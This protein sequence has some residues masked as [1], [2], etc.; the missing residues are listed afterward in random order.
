M[1]DRKA[2]LSRRHF[3]FALGAGGA[4]TAA[5]ITARGAALNPPAVAAPSDAR[6]G[7]GYRESAHVARYYDSTR[8]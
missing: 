8:I 6:R 1:S 7:A 3:L 4:A 5:T 2:R